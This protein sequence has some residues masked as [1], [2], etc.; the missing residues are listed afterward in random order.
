M[1]LEQLYAA[2][3]KLCLD[4]RAGA[5]RQ[6][7]SAHPLDPQTFRTYRAQLML[8]APKA[9]EETFVRYLDRTNEIATQDPN[10]LL[11]EATQTL[12][13]DW[14][15]AEKALDELRTEMQLDLETA[16]SETRA[17]LD[18]GSTAGRNLPP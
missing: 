16:R 10:D 13:V 18:A 12:T 6:Q 17:S 1:R 3:L 7:G 5:F 15:P 4:V 14:T 9:V 11:D 8:L 2:V